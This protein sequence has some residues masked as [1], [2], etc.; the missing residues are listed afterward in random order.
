M[1][2]LFTG[3]RNRFANPADLEKVAADYP[4]ATWMHGGAIGFDSQVDSY[5]RAHGIHTEVHLPDYAQ[6]G[7]RAP[8]VRND[9]MLETCD[10]VVALWDGRTIGGTYYVLRKARQERKPIRLLR[11]RD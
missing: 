8:L 5:A 10:G 9:E 2:I 3:H 6:Y 7:R 4:G 1:R 11:A